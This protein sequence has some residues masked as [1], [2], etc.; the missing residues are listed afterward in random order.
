MLLSEIPSVPLVNNMADESI[1]VDY[2]SDIETPVSSIQIRREMEI[3]NRSLDNTIAD[4]MEETANEIIDDINITE[5]EH[6]SDE[7]I[8]SDDD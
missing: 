5:I 7:S 4:L 6:A 3:I 8:S 1:S 2:E